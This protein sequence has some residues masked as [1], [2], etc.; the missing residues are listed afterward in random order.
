ML[1]IV[2]FQPEIPQNTGNIARTCVATGSK[3]HLIK[4]YSFTLSEKAVKRAGLD[5]WSYLDLSEYNSYDEFLAA[6]NPER[7][8]ALTTKA[9][10]I[11]TDESFRD[12]DYFLFGNEDSGLPE[13]IHKSL[14]GRR[15]RIPM[16]PYNYARCL[17]VANS[18]GIVLYEAL[19]QIG[20][21][22]LG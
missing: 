16:M 14:E 10:K 12:E 20:F 3:L 11:Y 13:G 22:G 6:C 7:L 15:L 18:V 17:N 5:Y 9:T 19:R 4:P 1:N 2:L 21:G 8:F